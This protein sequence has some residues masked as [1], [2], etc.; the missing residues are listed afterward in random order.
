VVLR[1][2]PA[3]AAVLQEDRVGAGESAFGRERQAMRGGLARSLDSRQTLKAFL[4]LP[5]CSSEVCCAAAPL[6]CAAADAG[7]FDYTFA[8]LHRE[9]ATS[10]L[11]AGCMSRKRS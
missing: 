5:I 10:A 11:S 8:A 9:R 2:C 6:C 7:K 1:S 4:K 3:T